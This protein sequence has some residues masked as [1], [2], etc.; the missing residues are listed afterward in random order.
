MQKRLNRSTCRLGCGLQWA[1]G[2]TSSIV[3]AR[4]RQCTLIRG[5]AAGTCRTTLNHPSTAAM[6]FMANYFDHWTR[7]L[8]QSHRQPSASSR[9]LY[10]GH[11][12]QYSHLV[13]NINLTFLD[14][15]IDESNLI[16]KKCTVKGFVA[17]YLPVGVSQ[18]PYVATYVPLCLKA[19]AVTQSRF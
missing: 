9:V 8:T 5:H 17:K 13:L 12:T 16:V 3:F 18:K 4:W 1:E 7:P 2:C 11:S 19:S 10:Y 6:R 14:W 15:P